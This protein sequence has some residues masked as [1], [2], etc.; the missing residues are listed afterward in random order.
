MAGR[1]KLRRPIEVENRRPT[2]P[3]KDL[4]AYLKTAL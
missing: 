4:F 3:G 1:L 2:E